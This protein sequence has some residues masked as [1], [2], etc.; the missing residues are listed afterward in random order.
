MVIKGWVSLPISPNFWGAQHPPRA[1]RGQTLESHGFLASSP[2]SLLQPG[3]LGCTTLSP[4]RARRPGLFG[5]V[6]GMPR[7]TCRGAARGRPPVDARHP[8]A[9]PYA[10]AVPTPAAPASPPAGP[11]RAQSS[12]LPAA[13]ETARSRVRPQSASPRLRGGP[14]S[15]ARPMAGGRV[16]WRGATRRAGPAW[17]GRRGASERSA[18]AVPPARTCREGW[19]QGCRS[20]LA[21]ARSPLKLCLSPFNGGTGADDPGR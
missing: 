4:A 21:R 17:A 7:H 10:C 13:P 9:A 3:G 12:N 14:A 18:R 6:T 1:S 2:R 15:P 20:N 11:P 19:W 5:H 8:G 16:T